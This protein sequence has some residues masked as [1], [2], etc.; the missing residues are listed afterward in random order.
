MRNPADI[1]RKNCPFTTKTR[2]KKGVTCRQTCENTER[3]GR[4]MQID[5][6]ERGGGGG[7]EET[8]RLVLE[9]FIL[10]G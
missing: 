10:Q 9:N 4:G 1:S 7:R 5:K 2:G 6:T 8:E 3:G